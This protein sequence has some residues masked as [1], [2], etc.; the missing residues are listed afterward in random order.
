MGNNYIFT[1]QPTFTQGLV[2]GQISILCLLA[3]ILKYLFIETS[4]S[5]VESSTYHPRLNNESLRSHLLPTHDTDDDEKV[6]G[7]ESAEWFNVLLQQAG[8]LML[9][10]SNSELTIHMARLL[11]SIARNYEM[12]YQD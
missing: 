10:R 6:N 11:R 3:V 5:P 2:F 7:E 8:A 4:E 1:L 9:C 12:I